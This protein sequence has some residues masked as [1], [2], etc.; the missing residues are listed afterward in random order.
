MRDSKKKMKSTWGYCTVCEKFYEYGEYTLAYGQ[1][2][3]KEHM[4]VYETNNEEAVR[5]YKARS[6]MK[7]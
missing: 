4:K 7:Y 2:L 3:C 6:E 1:V 5:F